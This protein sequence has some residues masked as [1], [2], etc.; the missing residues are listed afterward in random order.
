M[1]ER[2][3]TVETIAG[4]ESSSP[5]TMIQNFREPVVMQL[6]NLNIRHVNPIAYI[7]VS[8]HTLDVSDSAAHA[9]RCH[10]AVA[11]RVEIEGPIAI[12]SASS[13]GQ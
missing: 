6:R 3:Y 2:Q 11:R 12:D 7:I 5:Q 1:Q 8:Y 13:S 9:S 10:L 4:H